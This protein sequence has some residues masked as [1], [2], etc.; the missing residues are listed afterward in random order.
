MPTGSASAIRLERQDALFLDF[1]G[2]LTEIVADPASV[3]LAPGTSQDL[4]R[5]SPLLGGALAIVSGRD[6][7]D[8]SLR[9][10]GALWRIGSHGT[11]ICRPNEAPPP[12]PAEAPPAEILAVLKAA[13]SA[14]PG[15]RLEIKGAV[16]ALHFR[17][18]PAAQAACLGAAQ[19]AA[20]A[21]AGYE[22]QAGKMVVEVKPASISKGAVVLRLMAMAPFAG[23]RAVVFGDD[24][25]D[26]TAFE[27][28]LGRG[29]IAV[30]VGEGPSLAQ[31]RIA[32]P[33]ELRRWIRTELEA[34][35]GR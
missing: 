7:R 16:A 17:G 19:H 25:T 2:T 22:V 31:A 11:E 35:A 1:D 3:F 4:Q 34:L 23:R 30:K 14:N 29:G 20:R 5:L 33:Q 8:L 32:S 12:T 21:G 10:P 24:T 13:V 26:E 18:A 28:V 15:V 6:I 9:V 27:A